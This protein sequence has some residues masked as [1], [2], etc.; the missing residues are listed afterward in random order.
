MWSRHRELSEKTRGS[1]LGKQMMIWAMLRRDR[2]RDGQ[3]H[4]QGSLSSSRL[5]SQTHEGR[6][7]GKA[8]FVGLASANCRSRACCGS[9]SALVFGA[10]SQP[11]DHQVDCLSASCSSSA[12]SRSRTHSS[13]RHWSIT[14]AACSPQLR[15]LASQ[16]SRTGLAAAVVFAWREYG[17]QS[18]QTEKKIFSILVD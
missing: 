11:G 14:T 6:G 7:P 18:D 8:D 12:R 16:R 5:Q 9:P 3:H 1:E 15:H 4:L 2:E 10:L 17:P 13:S